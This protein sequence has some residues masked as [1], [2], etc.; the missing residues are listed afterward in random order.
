MLLSQW[1]GRPRSRTRRPAARRAPRLAL[2]RLEDRTLLTFTVQATPP[3]AGVNSLDLVAADLNFDGLADVATADGTYAPAFEPN[4]TVSI[5]RNTTTA[6]TITFADAVRFPVGQVPSRIAAGDFNRDGKPDLLTLNVARNPL[7]T[8]PPTEGSVSVLLNTTAAAGGLITFSGAASLPTG[9]DPNA[10]VVADFN[11]DG[12]LDFAVANVDTRKDQ[13]GGV[14][15]YLGNGDGTFGAPV[16]SPGGMNPNG[17]AVGD[18]NL[19]SIPDLVVLNAI[20]QSVRFLRGVG[21]GTFV[22]TPF[23]LELEYRPFQAAAGDVNLDGKMDVLVTDAGDFTDPFFPVGGSVQVLRGNGDGTFALGT[24]N[25]TPNP[26]SVTAGDFNGDTFPDFATT[27]ARLN[28]GIPPFFQVTYRLGNGDGTFRPLVTHSVLDTGPSSVTA[29]D[30]N[31]DRKPDL[32]A[33]SQ[34]P[35]C[36]FTACDSRVSLLRSNFAVAATPPAAPTG[37]GVTAG[38]DRL[39]LGWIDNSNNETGF[40]VERSADGSTFVP[41]ATVGPNVTT[42]TNYLSSGTFSYRVKA[43]NLVGESGYSNVDSGTVGGGPTPPASNATV[44]YWETDPRWIGW[45]IY[46]GPG[47]GGADRWTDPGFGGALVA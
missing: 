13:V 3:R 1:L 27:S 45:V 11:A 42:F 43:V 6:T 46:P 20:S 34:E 47:V 17:L 26:S 22:L 15:V 4:G 39:T 9:Y 25:D 24:R 16:G 14:S 44:L 36:L 19:D 31:G 35:G 32:A 10:L 7:T 29:A 37:L 2:E 23:V 5:L 38:A 30:F 41:I 40:V 18:F 8:S 33:S 12:A 21:N 28:L